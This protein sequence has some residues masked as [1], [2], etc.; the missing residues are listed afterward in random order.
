M[1]AEVF[2]HPEG[3]SGEVRPK[4]RNG[5]NGHNG[6]NGKHGQLSLAQMEI[7]Y[8]R[9]SHPKAEE[10][11]IQPFPRR[12]LAE[13][14]AGVWGGALVGLLFGVLLLYNVLVVPGWG[15]LYS[16]SPLTF[17]IFWVLMGLAGGIFV[18]A[19]R[20]FLP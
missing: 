12:V 7:E 13:L 6:H 5:H 20:L 16:M 11:P 4:G 9:K 14:W 15:P 18:A 2:D 1:S 17:L 8:Y 19:V 10:P 3:A